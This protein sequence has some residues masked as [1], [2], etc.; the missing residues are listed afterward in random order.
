VRPVPAVSRNASY[1]DASA[2]VLKDVALSDS[3]KLNLTL[4]IKH[5]EVDPLFRSL[6]ASTQADKLSNDFSIVASAGET[7]AQF[8][9][10]RFNDNL[11]NIPSILKS[12]TRSN[13]FLI[14]T[15][16]ASLFGSAQKPSPFLPRVSYGFSE[17]HQFGAAIPV[18]GG[19]EL[20]RSAIPDQV[21]TNQSFTADWQIHKLRFGYRLNRSFQ[22]NQ[23]P[24]RELTDFSNLVDGFSVGLSPAQS[25]DLT[26]DVNAERA[27][28]LGAHTRDST[29]RV[30]PTINWRIGKASTL[31]ANLSTTVAGDRQDTRHNDNVEFDAQW[32]YRFAVMEK[33]RFRKMQWQFFTRYANHYARTR[34]FIVFQNDLQRTQ[35][36]NLG[37]SVNL[38]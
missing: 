6:A 4:S 15:P 23:Q 32:T 19:F 14:G 24:G 28:N 7:T 34:N 5:E 31:A 13:T 36:L 18:N 9:H 16:L 22:D 2:E 35:T 27:S 37:L 38:F 20:D 17:V 33:S 29:M 30:A 26:L 25:L 1:V 10:G 21:A 12:L 3:R 8:T 11:A